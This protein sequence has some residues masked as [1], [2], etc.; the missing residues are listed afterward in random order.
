MWSVS[1]HQKMSRIE[2]IRKIISGKK[3]KGQ[4]LMVEYSEYQ[5]YVCFL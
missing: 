2:E 3:K 1:F 5:Q 4:E